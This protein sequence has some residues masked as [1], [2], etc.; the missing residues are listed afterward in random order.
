MIF[1][2]QQLQKE[3]ERC[4]ECLDISTREKLIS[5]MNQCII[6]SHLVSFTTTDKQQEFSQLVHQHKV[7]DL[8]RLIA[9]VR[10]VDPEL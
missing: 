9:N 8:Q 2:E 4:S 5:I 6:T 1:G 3:L 7:E 10:K